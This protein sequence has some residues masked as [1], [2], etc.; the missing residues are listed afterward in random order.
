MKTIE[1]K[2]KKLRIVFEDSIISKNNSICVI[3]K[4]AVIIQQV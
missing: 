1:I 4:M 3:I 2:N